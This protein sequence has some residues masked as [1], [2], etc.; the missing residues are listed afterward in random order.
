MS[1]MTDQKISELFSPADGCHK[2]EVEPFEFDELWIWEKYD[3]LTQEDLEEAAMDAECK[4]STQL[5][6][7]MSAEKSVAMRRWQKVEECQPLLILS[8][9]PQNFLISVLATLVAPE[10]PEDKVHLRLSPSANDCLNTKRATP[11]LPIMSL[12]VGGL[13]QSGF[14]QA[15]IASNWSNLGLPPSSMA[16]LSICFKTARVQILAPN[17]FACPARHFYKYCMTNAVVDLSQNFQ[18]LLSA[19]L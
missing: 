5:S 1:R 3:G 9:V 14:F 4:P 11:F 8:T 19:S 16:N 12:S 18:K 7:K 13:V 17:G 10:M 6:K 2:F 15:Q